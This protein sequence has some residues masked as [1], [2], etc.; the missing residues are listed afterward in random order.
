MTISKILLQYEGV[1]DH[2]NHRG[3]WPLYRCVSGSVAIATALLE[4]GAD[5]EARMANGR[6]PLHLVAINGKIDV[7][8]LL[9]W[10]HHSQRIVIE[11]EVKYPCQKLQNKA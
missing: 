11:V 8:T 6:S 4:A 7:V 5:K 1:T 9:F 3:T 2:R 10:N